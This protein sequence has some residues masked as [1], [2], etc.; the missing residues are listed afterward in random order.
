M[1]YD[2]VKSLI[3][4]KRYHDALTMLN[5]EL[6][7][8]PD[9][10]R[11]LFFIG[12]IMVQQDRRG[13]AYN[14]F[15]RCAKHWPD[16]AEV[17]VQFGRCQDDTPEG[18]EKSEWCFMKAIQINPNL[19][20]PYAQMAYLETQRCQPEKAVDW[21]RRCFEIEPDYSVAWSAIGFASLM[22][23]DWELGWKHYDLKLGDASR[24]NMGYGDIPIWDGTKGKNVIV[25]GE[26]GIGDEILFASALPDMAK[27]CGIVY[28]TMPRLARLMQ[29][30]FPTIDVVGGRWDGEIAL[31]EDW[32]PDARISQ[33][34]ILQHYRKKDEDYPGKPYLAAHPGMRLQMRA[35]LDSLGDKPKVGIAWTGGTKRSRGHFRQKPLEDLYPLLS[36]DV[37]WVSLQYK[38][39]SD[40]ID[41]AP[42]MIHHFDWITEEKDYDPTAALVAEL[43]LVITVPT[44]VSQLSGALGTPCWVMV[45]EITGW[46]FSRENYVWADSVKLYRNK[47]AEFMRKELE[48]WLS[49]ATQHSSPRLA[50]G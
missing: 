43:D 26:Q 20:Y 6:D 47:P 39:C 2:I 49:T 25:Y 21:A 45:P 17:W 41:Q 15:A 12:N 35:L 13:L 38:N 8:N 19:V 18:W 14:I 40:E 23:G 32:K 27:D 31:P 7:S 22:L 10:P 36:D 1:N 42:V 24:P 37:T 34:S 48:R 29:R 28:D 3:Q 4:A 16:S 30:S 9:D 33:A 46:L 11:A 50:T 5:D 44:S